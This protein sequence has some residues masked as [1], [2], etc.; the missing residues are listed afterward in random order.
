[1]TTFPGSPKTLRGAVVLLDPNSGRLK[2][3]ITLQFNPESLS[4][5]LQI[6]RLAGESWNRSEAFRLSRPP[7]ETIM[8]D[9][10]ENV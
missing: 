8:F 4:R 6:Q 5:S 9:T 1:M 10:L 3:F 7:V 2:R